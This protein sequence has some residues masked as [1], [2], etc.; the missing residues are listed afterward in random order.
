MNQVC[1]CLPV[2]RFNAPG[3]SGTGS[4]GGPAVCPGWSRWAGHHSSASPG[5]A[6][7]LFYHRPNPGH[8]RQRAGQ[9][10][11]TRCFLL[12]HDNTVSVW[13]HDCM[14]M[15]EGPVL[16]DDVWPSA[17]LRKS[18]PSSMAKWTTHWQRRWGLWWKSTWFWSLSWSTSSVRVSCPCRSFGSIYSPPWGPWRYWLLLVRAL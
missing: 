14:C 8:V 3:C 11:I 6:E 17:S 5:E 7:P 16:M 12:L 2:L 1:D 9:Q 15:T 10:N 13:K 4:G 18:P